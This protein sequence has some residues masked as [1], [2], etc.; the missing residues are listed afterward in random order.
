MTMKVELAGRNIDITDRIQE[1]VD[2]KIARLDRYMSE[3]EEARVELAF[4]KSARSAA[5]RQ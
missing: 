5:D 2:K 4:V 1:Y 3:V